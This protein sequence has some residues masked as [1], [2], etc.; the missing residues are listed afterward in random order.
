MSEHHESFD[1]DTVLHLIAGFVGW[2]SAHFD[3]IGAR[4]ITVLTIVILATKLY[5]MNS[6]V[7]HKIRHRKK[8]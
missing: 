5:R 2:V 3:A 8:K 7:I 6:H 1:T 4:V